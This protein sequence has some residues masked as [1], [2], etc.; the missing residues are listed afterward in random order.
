MSHIQ[1]MNPPSHLSA[2]EI[3]NVIRQTGGFTIDSRWEMAKRPQNIYQ[4]KELLPVIRRIGGR[5]IRL[6][7]M[8]GNLSFLVRDEKLAGLIGEWEDSSDFKK[9][10]EE[11][12]GRLRIRGGHEAEINDMVER[13]DD[14][15]S[16]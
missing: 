11:A 6:G 16:L 1:H 2:S 14:S 12:S 4:L 13:L 9:I 3:E 15:K 8:L 5:D 7:C 10:A